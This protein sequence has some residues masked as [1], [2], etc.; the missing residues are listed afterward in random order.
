M[1]ANAIYLSGCV[2]S[3]DTR[4]SSLAQMYLAWYMQR[5]AMWKSPPP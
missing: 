1:D 5:Y 4:R 2:R 3:D